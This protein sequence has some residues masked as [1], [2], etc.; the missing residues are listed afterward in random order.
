M[1]PTTGVMIP[2]GVKGAPVHVTIPPDMVHPGEENQ[3]PP[4][5]ATTVHVI[6]N[7]VCPGGH[8]GKSP[9]PQGCTKVVTELRGPLPP[10]TNG[11]TSIRTPSATNITPTRLC[12]ESM[13]TNP[14]K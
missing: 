4:E 9:A 10:G 5:V 2:E 11:M 8:G 1:M 6:V 13:T 3:S 7:T 12:F 14:H